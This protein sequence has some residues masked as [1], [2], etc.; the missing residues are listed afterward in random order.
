M[1]IQSMEKSIKY[2]QYQAKIDLNHLGKHILLTKIIA[3]LGKRIKDPLLVK[4]K[5]LI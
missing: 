4:N 5:K 3:F 1:L 2:N